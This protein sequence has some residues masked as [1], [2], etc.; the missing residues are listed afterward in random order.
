ML[1]LVSLVYKHTIESCYGF[2]TADRLERGEYELSKSPKS[3][4]FPQRS[5]SFTKF[6]QI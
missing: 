1:Q 3:T 4:V 5:S 2:T 6:Y